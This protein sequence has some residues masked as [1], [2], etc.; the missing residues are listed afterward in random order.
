MTY[1]EIV[2]TIRIEKSQDMLANTNMT[3]S[4]ISEAIGYDTTEHYIRQFK[5][6]TNMTPSAFRKDS[7]RTGY[8]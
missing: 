8:Y 4:N 5:K 1:T 6:Y 3:V 2:R 7:S